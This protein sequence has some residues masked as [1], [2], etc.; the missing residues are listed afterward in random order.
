MIG[1]NIVKIK[2]RIALAC[3]RA[4]RDLSTIKLVSVSKGRSLEE[5]E[6][7]IA[8]GILDIGENKVQEAI[9]KYKNLSDVKWHML[10]HLQSNKVKD[11]LK[12]FDLIH[13]VDSLGLARE[14]DKQAG[15]INKIQDILIEIKTSFEIEKSGLRPEDAIT[16]IDEM[17]KLSHINIKG[18]M[19]IAPIARNPQEARPYFRL[20]R[21][22]RDKI[23]QSWFLSMGM[24][25]DFEI[26][27]EEGADIIRIGRG[28][29]GP[30]C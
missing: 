19:T 1:D 17:A 26:A 28:I 7:A 20:L 2:E 22:L 24:T 25:D 23:N 5:I 30:L 12:I 16:A 9:L 11:A 21:E 18:L 29:F 8:C 15:R 6:E 13:S 27:I 3:L 14:V 4:K 10:G